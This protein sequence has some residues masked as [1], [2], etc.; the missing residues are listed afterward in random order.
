MRCSRC[1]DAVAPDGSRWGTTGVTDTKATVP[2]FDSSLCCIVMSDSQHWTQS[3]TSWEQHS[4]FHLHDSKFSLVV[5]E[6]PASHK[7][8]RKSRYFDAVLK[9]WTD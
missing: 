1:V 4:A 9:P 2:S 6:V 7:M 5:P 3:Q 8:H